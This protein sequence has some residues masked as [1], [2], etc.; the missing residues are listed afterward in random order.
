M[1]LF[2][3]LKEFLLQPEEDE[4]EDYA[5]DEVDANG[6]EEEV[7]Y[8]KP[9]ASANS[10]GLGDEVPMVDSPY[11]DKHQRQARRT[12]E[13]VAA[14]STPQIKR[15]V[16][17]KPVSVIHVVEPRMYDDEVKDIAT[18]LISGQA[19]I[20][21]FKKVDAGDARQI[22]DFISGVAFAISGDMQKIREDIF[23][24]TP[25]TLSVE[26]ILNEEENLNRFFSSH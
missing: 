2:D 23:I 25:A 15:P 21:N 5:S 10:S 26:G 8:Q 12:A 9:T 6:E 1:G 18:E 20:I 7:P 17:T 22:V 24:A 16:A 3:S 13:P 4:Y 19:V 14:T 11:S